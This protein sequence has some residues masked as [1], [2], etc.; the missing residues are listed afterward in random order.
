MK[1][2]CTLCDNQINLD[3]KVFENYVGPVKCFA[4]GAM[5]EVATDHGLVGSIKAID[6][7]ED[8]FDTASG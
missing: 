1:V 3:H 6:N 7:V 2:N 5:L 4:C 8:R